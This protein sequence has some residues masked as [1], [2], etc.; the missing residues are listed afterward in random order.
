MLTQQLKRVDDEILILLKRRMQTYKKIGDMLRKE[1][2]SK[3]DSEEI[4]NEVF[5]HVI[6]RAKEMGMSCSVIDEMFSKIDEECM[7]ELDKAINK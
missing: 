4:S 3:K 7:K 6:S 1:N 5:E 2:K